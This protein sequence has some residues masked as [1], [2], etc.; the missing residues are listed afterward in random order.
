[1]RTGKGRP[2]TTLSVSQTLTKV[3][4]INPNISGKEQ[5]GRSWSERSE[6]PPVCDSPRQSTPEGVAY[7]IPSNRWSRAS[8]ATT[9][10]PTSRHPAAF[11]RLR[12][13]RYCR[14]IVV[15]N[16]DVLQLPFK[17]RQDKPRRP[18]AQPPRARSARVPF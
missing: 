9:G 7:Q 8:R 16:G 11:A 15:T 10:Y 2:L 12:R 17:Q 5:R 13:M 18:R 4:R 3:E 6:R 14:L 1:M